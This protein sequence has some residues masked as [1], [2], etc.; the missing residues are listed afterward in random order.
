M[1]FACYPNRAGFKADGESQDAAN[2]IEGS[3]QASRLRTAVLGF[4]GR[5]SG[6][7]DECAASLGES[8]LSIR[9]RCSELLT[10]GKLYRTGERRKSSEG[11]A[12]AVL[13]LATDSE[14]AA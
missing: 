14:A 4:Y 6:T 9:P 10:Q 2:A 5:R 3:G 1:N 12:Q 13:A 7:A 8:I 11:R